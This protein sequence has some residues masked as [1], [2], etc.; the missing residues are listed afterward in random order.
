MKN[1]NYK[2]ETY[3]RFSL[4]CHYTHLDFSSVHKVKNMLDVLQLDVRGH[5]HHRVLAG[6]LAEY[7]LKVGR[8]GTQDDLMGLDGVRGVL[9]NIG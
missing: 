9:V 6:V 4:E 7:H 8:G 5:D 2:I 1:K 3:N